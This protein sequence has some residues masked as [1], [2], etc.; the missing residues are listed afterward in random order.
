MHFLAVAIPRAN[1]VRETVLVFAAA[2]FR[3]IP[4]ETILGKIRAIVRR[5]AAQDCFDALSIFAAVPERTKEV[6]VTD[7]A[8]F[9]RPKAR[10]LIPNALVGAGERSVKTTSLFAGWVSAVA[11]DTE[12]CSTP[13]GVIA[14]VVQ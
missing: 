14:L 4:I 8:F 5:L 11:S 13:L 1:F 9:V 7:G 2:L 10:S 3:A 6:N 12:P